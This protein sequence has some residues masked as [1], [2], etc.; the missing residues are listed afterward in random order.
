MEVADVLAPGGRIVI[1]IRDGS[2]MERVDPAVFTV[3]PPT[4]IVAALN[5]AGFTGVEID[6]VPEGTSHLITAAR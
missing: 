2:V 3:R 6:T 5:S 1:G 4:E